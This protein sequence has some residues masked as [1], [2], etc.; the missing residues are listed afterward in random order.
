MRKLLQLHV[1]VQLGFRDEANVC[2]ALAQ[3]VVEVEGVG[4]EARHVDARNSELRGCGR[5]RIAQAPQGEKEVEVS[6]CAGLCARGAWRF[7]GRAKRSW[8]GVCGREVFFAHLLF[9]GGGP[10]VAGC[11]SN[12]LP[13]GCGVVGGRRDV[14]PS[15][16]GEGGDGGVPVGG[17]A[18]YG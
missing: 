3:K 15:P 10:G 14:T 6:P 4:S 17:S 11:R 7:W 16:Y 8:V 12:L 2:G 5:G 13:S 18:P 1:V 9:L